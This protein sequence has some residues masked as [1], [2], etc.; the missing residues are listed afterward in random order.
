MSTSA[1]QQR[2]RSYRQWKN[3]V[4]RAIEDLA[5]WLE[6]HRRATPRARGQLGAALELLR[7]DRLAVAFVAEPSRGKTELLNALF[8]SEHGGQLLPAEAGRRA[9]CPIEL[10]WD[11][12]RG[13][14]YL[15]LLPVESRA[16]DTPIAQLK[17]H[18]KHWVHYPLNVQAPEQMAGTLREIRQTKTVS[19]AEATRLGLSSLALS[20]D[21]QLAAGDLEIPKWRYAIL[22]FPHPLLEQGLTVL[23][24]SGLDVLKAEPELTMDL[25]PTAQAVI[26]VLAADAGVTRNDLAIWQHHLKGFQSGRQ[27]AM[28]T[29]LNGGA[30]AS[31]SQRRH[32]AQVLGIGEEGVFPVSVQRAV[33]GKTHN[34]ETL[35]GHSG[36]PILERHLAMRMLETKHQSLAEAIDSSVGQILDRNRARVASRIARLKSQLEELEQLRD[37]SQDV[38]GQLLEKTRRE[39]ER[40]LRGVDRFQQGREELLVE[41]RPCRRILER[42]NI[43][44][45]VERAHANLMRSWTTI[46]L[47][48]A[49]KGLFEE[50]RRTMQDVATES[51]RIRKLVREMYQIFREDFELDTATPKVFMPMKFRVEIELL[52]QELEAF[53]RS[54]AMI[55]SP[56]PWIVRRFHQQMVSRAQVLFDQLGAA[57]DGWIRESLQPLAEEIEEHKIAMEKRLENLQRIGRSKDALQKRIDDMQTQYVAFAQE[58]TALRNI[59]NALHYDPLTE[60]EAPQ[61]P[62]LVSG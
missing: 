17:L 50:L 52:F 35:L 16:Q 20:A 5:T 26:F 25:L 39:Q 19:L 1:L 29:V 49:M 54:P 45:I 40:Y 28:L 15:R 9:P 57:Y 6:E 10:S 58:L 51:E 18:S 47:V 22:S 14:A 60:Q 24:I 53:R 31:E 23:D 44:S 43:D 13:E 41:T 56:R 11:S 21:A 61:R 12:K 3:R 48:H 34:D 8:F 42:E 30:G 36:L 4:A 33:L 7:Q 46:G 32:A 27:R 2:L 37:K 59:H 55:L 38:T 62:R